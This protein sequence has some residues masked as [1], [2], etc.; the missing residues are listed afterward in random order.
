MANPLFFSGPSIHVT[1]EQQRQACIDEANSNPGE[2]HLPRNRER[3]RCQTDDLCVICDKIFKRWLWPTMLL[4]DPTKAEAQGGIFTIGWLDRMIA[5]KYCSLCQFLAELSSRRHYGLNHDSENGRVQCFTLPACDKVSPEGMRL[6][7]DLNVTFLSLKVTER[8]K[9]EV[10]LVQSQTPAVRFNLDV[11]SSFAL[12]IFKH[13]YKNHET[14]TNLGQCVENEIEPCFLR[15]AWRLC[16]RVHGKNCALPRHV[17]SGKPVADQQRPSLNIRVIDVQKRCLVALPAG[18]AYVV[19]SYTWTPGE[20]L[21]LSQANCAELHVVDSIDVANLP[22]TIADAMIVVTQIEERYLWADRLCIIQDSVQ[23]KSVQIQQM[24]KVYREAALTIVAAASGDTGD[25]G[26][27]GVRSGSRQAS[28]IRG[29]FRYLQ[30]VETRTYMQDLIEPS[31]WYSRAWTFQEEKLS[32]RFLVF[33]PSRA[34]LFCNTDVFAE[35]QLRHF[36]YHPPE[37]PPEPPYSCCGYRSPESS[38]EIRAY[39]LGRALNDYEF[40]VEGYS[41]RKLTVSSDILKGLTGMLAAISD[42]TG[43]RFLCGMPVKNLLS[44][45]LMWYPLDK[46]ERRLT[47]VT[48]HPFPSWSWAGWVGERVI[49]PTFKDAGTLVSDWKV[50]LPNSTNTSESLVAR[51]G[52]R[53]SLT[54]MLSLLSI[55]PF[56]RCVQRDGK[57]REE[58]D[59]GKLTDKLLITLESCHLSFTAESATVKLSKYLLGR[60]HISSTWSQDRRSQCRH[61]FIDKR[62]AGMICIDKAHDSSTAESPKSTYLPSVEE[63]MNLLIESYWPSSPSPSSSSSPDS[64][65]LQG[66]VIALSTTKRAFQVYFQLSSHGNDHIN[67][68]HPAGN[69][70][71]KPRPPYNHF[72]WNEEEP[73]VVNVMLIDWDAEGL[74]QRLGVGQIHGEAWKLVDRKRKKILLG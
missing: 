65:Y 52:N 1:T 19:L 45:H 35:D 69:D 42:E 7:W 71:T 9:N 17:L 15:T 50:I 18:A 25:A 44:H 54:S 14:L 40:M 29:T 3:P 43:D 37:K 66:E 36:C 12:R 33:T 39:G 67:M 27:P 58:I 21:S 68:N 72:K 11:E 53:E 2:W 74:A 30:F 55:K 60:F 26:L 23:D 5:T 59:P 51:S 61:V 24:D 62:F 34:A 46:A 16:T 20:H 56:D 38:R 31:R 4:I 49:F 10:H 6:S 32:K 57:H 48:G 28:Q 73:E 47:P 22:K 13:S 63:N 70:K 41:S 8:E 64:K